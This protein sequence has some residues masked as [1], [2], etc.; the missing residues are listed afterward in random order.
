MELDEDMSTKDTVDDG[1]S[2]YIRVE[3]AG[4]ANISGGYA[5]GTDK[6]ADSR[7][8]AEARQAIENA[9]NTK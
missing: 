4:S 5:A 7:R 9:I 8:F 3:T 6:D 1:S 2:Y